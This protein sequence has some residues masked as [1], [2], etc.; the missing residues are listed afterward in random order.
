MKM[1]VWSFIVDISLK[2]WVSWKIEHVSVDIATSGKNWLKTVNHSHIEYKW[3]N[4]S[5]W[6]VIVFVSSSH[7]YAHLCVIH[8]QMNSVIWCN[9]TLLCF[10]LIYVL[11]CPVV[12]SRMNLPMYP[13]PTASIS[14]VSN[15]SWK[16][17]CWY[18]TFP[19]D[20]WKIVFHF[21]QLA[22]KWTI[23]FYFWLFK[24]FCQFLPKPMRNL[25]SITA[26]GISMPFLM[27]VALEM[28]LQ[29][30]VAHMSGKPNDYFEW[31]KGINVQKKMKKNKKNKN[32]LYLE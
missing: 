19:S 10:I 13:C 7:F 12:K 24:W 14:T 6:T 31:K 30:H 17:Y 1:D 32:G 27:H 9:Q 26:N 18:F 5:F 25:A 20:K 29:V 23:S 3:R 2:Q 8:V 11:L 28:M 4:V 21:C 15:E 16:L 22:Y